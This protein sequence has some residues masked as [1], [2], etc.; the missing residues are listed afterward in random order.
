MSC[1]SAFLLFA[2]IQQNSRRLVPHQTFVRNQW[3]FCLRF[4][5]CFSVDTQ[6][7]QVSVTTPHPPKK[8]LLAF[9]VSFPALPVTQGAVYVEIQ[10]LL[11]SAVFSFDFCLEWES[12][13]RLWIWAP[14]SGQG[15]PLQAAVFPG[16]DNLM[17]GRCWLSSWGCRLSL[18]LPDCP[19]F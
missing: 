9:P 17:L 6:A 16:R 19:A 11:A 1:R 18:F 10:H 7:F 4:R 5:F 3:F 8:I 2:T 13:S 15:I 14:S 12:F